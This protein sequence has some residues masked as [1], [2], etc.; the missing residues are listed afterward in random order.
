MAGMAG[1]TGMAGRVRGVLRGKVRLGLGV[2]VGRGS[3]E[4]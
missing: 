3:V 2:L 4:G 1:M